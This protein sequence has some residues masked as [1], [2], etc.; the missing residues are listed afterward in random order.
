MDF[1][2]KSWFGNLRGF[3]IAAGFAAVFLALGYVLFVANPAAAATVENNVS[4]SGTGYCGATCS[5]AWTLADDDMSYVYAAWRGSYRQWDDDSRNTATVNGTTVFDERA[6][7][8]GAL[9]GWTGRSCGCGT[10]GCPGQDW[11]PART[12]FNRFGETSV[13]INMTVGAVEEYKTNGDLGAYSGTAAFGVAKVVCAA[14]QRN[15]DGSCVDISGSIT[16]TCVSSPC[17]DPANINLSYASNALNKVWIERNG[18][19]LAGY[20]PTSVTSGSLT[21]TNLGAGTYEYC[22]YGNDGS[23]AKISSKLGCS[24]VTV[25][26]QPQSPQA[27]I[28]ASPDSVSSGSS[29]TLTWACINST[30]A[31]LTPTPAGW[32]YGSGSGTISTG[33]LTST[34]T[35]TLTCSKPGF[36]SATA[37]ASVTVAASLAPNAPTLNFNTKG[38]TAGNSSYI[39]LNYAANM[40]PPATRIELYRSGTAGPIYTDSAPSNTTRQYTDSGLTGGQ[41]YTYSAIA[42]YDL[43]ASSQISTSAI[44]ASSCVPVPTVSAQ[45]N[46]VNGSSSFNLRDIKN[47]DTLRFRL[48]FANSGLG[49]ATR[50]DNT[51][52]LSPNLSYVGNSYSCAGLTALGATMRCSPN[53][54]GTPG[55]S[56]LTFY[57]RDNLGPGD[58]FYADFQVKVVTATSQ[59]RELLTIRSIG[60]YTPG[61]A[62]FDVTYSL[63]ASPSSIIN[64]DFREIAP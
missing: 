52:T 54:I 50:V 5:Q 2:P 28:S 10:S 49:A 14:G 1:F 47:G 43:L 48:S 17:E 38:C 29:S 8:F 42:Y 31:T 12:F 60:S 56:T 55:S 63:L 18:S 23:G 27:T 53:A 7:D 58:T 30:G 46:L 39:T 26:P 4:C 44:S 3:C 57:S 45:I 64:P 62:P 34:Q 36:A 9:N 6:Y 59:L 21:D 13:S 11:P 25:S 40:P 16:A 51:T 15:I 61:G 19:A 24:S 35:Y 20:N 41:S 33:P 37:N 22:L 32:S